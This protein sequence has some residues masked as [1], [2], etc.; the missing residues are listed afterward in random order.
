MAAI[1]LERVCKRFKKVVLRSG[2][3]T[4]KTAVTHLFTGDGASAQYVDALR[5]VSLS[6]ERGATLGIIGRNG[7]GK[8]TLV[9]MIAGI[10][11]PD[12][13]RV[14]T[15]GRVSA[16]IELGAGFHPEFTGRENIYING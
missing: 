5:D 3:T 16:L 7:S 11:M 13:G 4:L 1:I 8:S 12:G 6:V 9:R 15:E 10:Y 14:I 2:Y